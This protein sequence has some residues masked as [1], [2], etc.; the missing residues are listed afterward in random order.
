MRYGLH[1]LPDAFLLLA[2]LR[3]TFVHLHHERPAMFFFLAAW[4]VYSLLALFLAQVHPVNSPA[5]IFWFT[6]LTLAAWIY[7]APAIWVA[8]ARIFR[9]PVFPLA[10]AL[11]LC[12]AAAAVLHIFENTGPGAAGKI[13]TLNCWAAV[14]AGAIFIFAS[15]GAEAPD[16]LLWRAAGIFFIVYGYGYIFIGMLRPGAWAYPALV[17]ILAAVWFALAWRVGANGE[18]LFNLEKLGWIPELMPRAGQV[19]AKVLHV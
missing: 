4:L 6:W 5:Y 17:L 16:R 9:A 14:I 19:L 15:V 2:L 18:Q 1:L 8:S 13:L 3:M 7:G 10:I 12:L 11:L